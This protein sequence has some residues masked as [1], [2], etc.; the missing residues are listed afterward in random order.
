MSIYGNY[1]FE[2]NGR[3]EE[4]RELPEKVDKRRQ[5]TKDNFEQTEDERQYNKWEN[6]RYKKDAYR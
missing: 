5:R 2:S 6:E 4:D 1:L 3:S